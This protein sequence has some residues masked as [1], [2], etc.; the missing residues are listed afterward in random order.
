MI[1]GFAYLSRFKSQEEFKELCDKAHADGHGVYA[2]TQV[3]WKNGE[4]VGY[5]SVGSPG[6]PLV[7][8]WLSTKDKLSTRDSFHLIN[9]IES[10][11][12]AGGASAVAFPVPQ[13]SP[14]LP[15]MEEMGFKKAGE[16]TFF[17]KE[18]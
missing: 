1:N 9:S 10:L 3:I 5:F 15:L 13:D 12:A 18:L 7:F 2:P 14:F 8:A 4:R 6:V 11:C 16:Y 17:I